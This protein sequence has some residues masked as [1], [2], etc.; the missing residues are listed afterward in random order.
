MKTLNEILSTDVYKI[1]LEFILYQDQLI[2][3][4]QKTDC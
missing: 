3:K 1:S 2:E 4:S